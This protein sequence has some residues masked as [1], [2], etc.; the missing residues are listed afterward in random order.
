MVKTCT[1]EN[2]IKF[3]LYWTQH[4]ESSWFN[5]QSKQVCLHHQH[6]LW[7]NCCVYMQTKQLSVTNC[8]TLFRKHDLSPSVLCP[9]MF[10]G[11]LSCLYC[12]IPKFSVLHLVF[13]VFT[14]E[15][16]PGPYYS[17]WSSSYVGRTMTAPFQLLRIFCFHD[18]CLFIV[19]VTLFT[20]LPG[21]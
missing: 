17:C 9:E 16:F 20:F 1:K 5:S 19:S 14:H 13:N 18:K 7:Q 12:S 11:F 6:Q 10:Q 21:V 3:V 15:I 8:K 2:Y 4:P